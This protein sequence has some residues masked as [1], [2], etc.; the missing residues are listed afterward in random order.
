MSGMV[1]ARLN[2]QDVKRLLRM[3]SEDARAEA[4]S[5]AVRVIEATAVTPADRT[6][7]GRMLRVIAQDTAERVRRAL[8]ESLRHSTLVPNDVALKLARDVD[9]VAIP[10]LSDSPVLQDKDLIHLFAGA[11]R[12]KQVAIAGRSNVSESLSHTVMSTGVRDA[13][14]TVLQNTGAKIQEKS[15][16]VAIDRFGQDDD[17]TR[18]MAV[19]PDLPIRVSERLINYVTDEVRQYLMRRHQLSAEAAEEIIDEARE[20]ATVDLLDLIERSSDM[21]ALVRQ[22]SLNGRLTASLV[23]RSACLGQMTFLEYAL[24]ELG[25]VPTDRTWILIH[26][27][28]PL[29]LRAI[30]ERASL[31]KQYFP[32]FRT[33]VDMFH[34][35]EYDGQPMDRER[36][37]SRL[38]ERILTRN[39]DLSDDD[40][41]Y[42]V[43]KIESLHSET[44]ALTGD[45]PPRAEEPEPEPA[46]EPAPAAP[47]PKPRARGDAERAAA[48]AKLDRLYGAD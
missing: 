36:F 40:I 3:P 16:N 21:R 25:Q 13:V 48:K 15:Y 45:E 2:E 26:D 37:C 18:L 24:S 17:I 10:M 30:Y 46:E 11:S 1:R 38:V 47:K 22:L 27:A 19:R 44:I 8:S 7:A 34:D 4:T 33:A 39:Q 12:N 35:T 9:S 43:S 41:D 31:P 20:R 42:L 14:K 23:L 32:A 28:G 29:G 5:Q 6:K